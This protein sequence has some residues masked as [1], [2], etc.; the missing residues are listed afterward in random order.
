MKSIRTEQNKIKKQA[1][2]PRRARQEKS[3]TAQNQPLLS[4]ELRDALL[5]NQGRPRCEHARPA[6]ADA[7]LARRRLSSVFHSTPRSRS[8]SHLPTNAMIDPSSSR[9]GRWRALDV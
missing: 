3:S 9:L 4:E 6:A 8:G 2:V 5:G 7:N 1:R